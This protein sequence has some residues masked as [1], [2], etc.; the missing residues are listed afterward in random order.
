MSSSRGELNA[1]RTRDIEVEDA[2]TIKGKFMVGYQGWFSCPGDG[3][4][5]E[6]EVKNG[7]DDLRRL[8]DEVLQLVR[9]SAEAEGRV[10]AI[11]YDVSG[12]KGEDVERLIKDDILHIMTELRVTE[13]LSYLHESAKPVIAI[14]G[15]GM[16]NDHH[17][18]ASLVRLMEW[19]Q[20]VSPSG[21]YVFA[22]TPS[23]WRTRDG[24]CDPDPAFSE[25]WRKVQNISPWYVGRF[26]D[27]EGADEFRQRMA[28]DMRF[29]KD[30][31]AA[32]EIRRDYTPVVFPGFSWTNLHAGPFNEIPRQGGTFLYRQLYNAIGEN[33]STVYGAMMDEMDEATALMPAEVDKR[34]TP[35]Q[36]PFLSLD[37]DGM[38][39]PDT[40]YMRI[41]ALAGMALAK[42]MHLP[43]R[44]P[45]EELKGYEYIPTLQGGDPDTI[46]DF[47]AMALNPP[48]LP[49]HRP[50][51]FQSALPM[52]PRLPA[53]AAPDLPPR[54]PRI[55]DNQRRLPP[56]PGLRPSIQEPPMRNDIRT[57]STAPTHASMEVTPNQA[58][59]LLNRYLTTPEN[60]AQANALYGKVNDATKRTFTPERKQQLAK[61]VETIGASGYKMFGKIR[62]AAGE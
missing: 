47:A 18:P 42:G 28:G 55:I 10:W 49:L 2:S 61:S 4:P 5:V 16:A 7:D 21:I 35:Q 26:A 54:V 57:T 1:T 45:L 17:S 3:K 12:V 27:V 52:A 36:V 60:Y 11:M 14:W 37:A 40:W 50:L 22:G 30:E 20:T 53:R 8:R 33:V 6:E 24:D 9:A 41:C 39:L 43:P 62:K 25:V 23:H 29:L 51:E 32:H 34:N 38:L 59:A 48:P 13:S 46:S 31:D 44:F 56:A 58:S 19:I 15:M